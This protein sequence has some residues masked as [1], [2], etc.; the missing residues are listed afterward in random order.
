[1]FEALKENKERLTSPF[2]IHATLL[3]VLGLPTLDEV[4]EEQSTT[5]R[6]L[7]LFRRISKSRTCEQVGDKQAKQ[8]FNNVCVAG[9]HRKSLVG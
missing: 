2:D 9:R 3:D 4:Q 7:S 8:R 1:M 5:E 6:S